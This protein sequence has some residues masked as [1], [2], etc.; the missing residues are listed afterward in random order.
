MTKTTK[1]IEQ[2]AY[3]K[4]YNDGWEDCE[5]H[6]ERKAKAIKDGIIEA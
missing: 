1:T 5:Q 3:E 4:G 2:E 6:K